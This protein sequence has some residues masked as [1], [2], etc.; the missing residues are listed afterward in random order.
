[1]ITDELG[2]SFGSLRISLTDLCNLACTYCTPDDTR[3]SVK[4]I[5]QQKKGK[6]YLAQVRGLHDVCNFKEVRLTGGEPLLF[7]GIEV[8]IAE[9]RNMG[10]P[11][12]KLTTNG[13]LLGKMASKLKAA[14]LENVNI[15]LDTIDAEL[16]KTMSRRNNLN[17]VLRGIDIAHELGLRPK[18]N[19]VI[20]KGVNDQQI[21]PLFRYFREKGIA[22]RF[23]EFM[24][25]GHLHHE[26]ERYFYPQAEILKQIATETKFDLVQRPKASTANYWRTSEGYQFGIIA[27][28]SRPFCEDCDRLR[29][30]S[31]GLVYGCLSND[32]GF[33]YDPNL[34]SQHDTKHIL[35]QALAQKQKNEFTGSELSMKFIGG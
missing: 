4:Q 28:T 32:K 34:S 12:V 10:I 3:L 19:T 6:Q 29:I 30:G 15:S 25:M 18:I 13:L 17:Q 33:S 1:M 27:N 11:K 26:Y 8:L 16:Y 5:T 20:M 24:Q 23:L 21:V 35:K 9:L 2:R 7:H 14:G 31:N 22:I